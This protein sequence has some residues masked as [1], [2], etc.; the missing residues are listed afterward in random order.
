MCPFFPFLNAPGNGCTTAGQAQMMAKCMPRECQ[1]NDVQMAKVFPIAFTL[2]LHPE[3]G[4][5]KT[6]KPEIRSC[7]YYL[8]IKLQRLHH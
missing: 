2:V 7:N 5:H 1:G 6:D 3:A 8:I 4:C